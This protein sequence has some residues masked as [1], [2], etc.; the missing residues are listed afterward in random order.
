MRKLV[1]SFAVHL[2]VIGFL[3]ETIVVF[4]EEKKNVLCRIWTVKTKNN[5]RN[6]VSLFKLC[7][8]R[9]FCFGTPDT[10]T[11]LDCTYTPILLAWL[12]GGFLK[13]WLRCNLIMIFFVKS[14]G[15]C[16][17]FFLCYMYICATCIDFIP[18]ITGSE[19]RGLG[20]GGGGKG[21]RFAQ[22]VILTL[23]IR[24]ERPEQTV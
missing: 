13:I 11:R 18:D 5:L 23:R 10:L 6:Q 3:E 7:E 12:T 24:T 16:L 4:H 21:G 22:I 19:A 2:L 1:W 17:D 8:H 20:W 15:S 14:N 9:I